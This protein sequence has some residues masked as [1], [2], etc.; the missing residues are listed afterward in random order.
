MVSERVRTLLLK[1]AGRI[2]DGD[3]DSVEP[4][5]NAWADVRLN[6]DDADELCACIELADWIV[7]LLEQYGET[8]GRAMLR[9]YIRLL[10]VP[11]TMETLQMMERQS[12]ATP[13]T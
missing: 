10:A 1:I 12:A 8:R 9:T 2:P 5:L 7:D 11:A 13:E 4:L 3:G 6:V